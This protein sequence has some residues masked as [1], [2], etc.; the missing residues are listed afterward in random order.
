MRFFWTQ[1]KE[2][3][4]VISSHGSRRNR[5]AFKKYYSWHNVYLPSERLTYSTLGKRKSS[6]KMP[7]EQ[8][9][10]VPID[11]TNTVFFFILYFWNI[12][13]EYSWYLLTIYLSQFDDITFRL[14]NHC[15]ASYC[16]CRRW[17]FFVLFFFEF[18]HLYSYFEEDFLVASYFCSDGWFNH[19]RSKKTLP[20]RPALLDLWWRVPTWLLPRPGN[21]AGRWV[22]GTIFGGLIEGV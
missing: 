21:N 4:Y 14:W 20:T 5:N 9:I 7:W 1:Q 2:P 22:M 19:L 15:V 16:T 18:V 11:S 13:F 17:C 6:S 8:D 3:G 10:L 12:I